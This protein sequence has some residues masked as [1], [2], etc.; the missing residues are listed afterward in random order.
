MQV[1]S[2]HPE[3]CVL[4]EE[5]RKLNKAISRRNHKIR[6]LRGKL[7]AATSARNWA[8]DALRAAK[9]GEPAPILPAANGGPLRLT[10]AD[11]GVPFGPP[12]GG[13]EAVV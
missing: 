1:N 12:Y 6:V 7:Q 4:R 8:L 13:E 11:R 5:I 3:L 2:I 10:Q 9:V